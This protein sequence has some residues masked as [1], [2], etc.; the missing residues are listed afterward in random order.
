MTHYTK[1]LSAAVAM[2]AVLGLAGTATAGVDAKA[3]LKCQ[4]TIAKELDKFVKGKSKN[5]QKC[6]EAVILKDKA[7]D[8]GPGTRLADCLSGAGDPLFVK[9][10]EKIAKGIVKF[11]SAIAKA[12]CGKDKTCGAGTGKDG[13]CAIADI[14][15]SAVCP[16]AGAGCNAIAIANPGDLADCLVCVTEEFV[17]G[18]VALV[19]DQ[20]LD[21]DKNVAKDEQKCQAKLGKESMKYLQGKHK[22]LLKCW[23]ARFK[24]KHGFDCPVDDSGKTAESIGKAELKYASA[25]CK[26]CGG[27]GKACDA[28]V[29]TSGGDLPGDSA[30][31]DLAPAAIG[32]VDPC[33]SIFNPIAGGSVGTIEEAFACLRDGLMDRVDCTSTLS[34]PSLSGALPLK[35]LE[36]S[37]TGNGGSVFVDVDFASSG[38]TP[39]GTV[40]VLS[41][42][43]SLVDIPGTAD[44]ASVTARVT[45]DIGG[46]VVTT[47]P[48]DQEVAIVVAQSDIF[49]YPG[50][51]LFTVEFDTCGAAPVD[52]DFTCAVVDASN[53]SGVTLAP[54]TVTC[55]ATVL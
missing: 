12:C 50:S 38:D 15:Y 52:G 34:V 17:D 4:Q 46:V 29:A 44:E 11:K 16:S 47:Q 27:A 51:D 41:Y 42:K 18:S 25:V 49:A 55:T 37:C 39:A 1:M 45:D 19:Y 6:V 10:G 32:T 13:D 8:G 20:M 2:T 26:A 22:N 31:D 14:G 48:N 28:L 35:C 21:L 5:L 53:E 54:G 30:G 36:P 40:V 24:G 43:P 3:T 33:P 23:S 7:P 9:T